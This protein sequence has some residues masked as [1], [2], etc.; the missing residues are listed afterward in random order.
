MSKIRRLLSHPYRNAQ[1][2]WRPNRAQMFVWQLAVMMLRFGILLFIFGLTIVL[3][4]TAAAQAGHW[5]L[6]DLKT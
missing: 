3:W 2:R 4:D 6:S 5:S 1:G